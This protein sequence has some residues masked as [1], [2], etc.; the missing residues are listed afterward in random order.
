LEA[1]GTGGCKAVK[2]L[3]QCEGCGVIFESKEAAEICE[4]SVVGEPKFQVGQTVEL[5]E[6]YRK[7]CVDVV[8]G[9]ALGTGESWLLRMYADNGRLADGLRAIGDKPLHEWKYTL[10]HPHQVSKDDYSEVFGESDLR[11]PAKVKTA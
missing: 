5:D 7:G 4:K 1:R 10:R 11:E 2:G 6:R 3:F 8:A 9:V